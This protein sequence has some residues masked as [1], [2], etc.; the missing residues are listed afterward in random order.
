MAD[1]HKTIETYLQREHV[2]LSKIAE[3][4]RQIQ[5]YKNIANDIQSRFE[6]GFEKTSLRLAMVDPTVNMEILRLRQRLKAKDDEI[7]DLK[8]EIASTSFKPTSI[9]GQK[10]MRKCRTLLEENQSL[11]RQISE[12]PIQDLLAFALMVPG[13]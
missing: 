2:Y 9:A 10:L 13:Q 6:E 3:Q 7:G 12:G 4:E 11:G 5:K 8:R 1:Q